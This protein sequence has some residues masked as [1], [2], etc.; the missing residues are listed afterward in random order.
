VF[1]TIIPFGFV[2]AALNYI[3]PTRVAIIATLEPVGAALVAFAWL[4]EEL[5]A[6]QLVGGT[7]VLAGVGLAQ[8]ARA[9]PRRDTG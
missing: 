4:G 8:T 1:G 9:A 3:V 2:V 7:L 6:I 5:T